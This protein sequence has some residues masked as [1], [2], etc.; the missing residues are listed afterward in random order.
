MNR[1]A[2]TAVWYACSLALPD[3]PSCIEKD[4]ANTTCAIGISDYTV[5]VGGR[6]GTCV[7]AVFVESRC[8]ESR[9]AESRCAESRCAESRCAESRCA[10]SRCA[11]SCCAESRCAALC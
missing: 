5:V 10:K 1:K 6:R 8:A 9:C 7:A 11:G 4:R 2:C 3:P